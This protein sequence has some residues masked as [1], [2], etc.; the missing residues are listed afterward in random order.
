VP[1]IA[2]A[3][4]F[5]GLKLAKDGIP[6]GLVWPMIVGIITSAIAGWFAVWGTLALLRK[7]SFL[8]FVIYRVL[9]GIAV[10][11]LAASSWR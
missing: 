10:L 9:L 8:P 4:L 2:G 11:G 6:D 5:K 7:T 1:V 3:L